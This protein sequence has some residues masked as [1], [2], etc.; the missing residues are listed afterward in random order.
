[1]TT[2]IEKTDAELSTVA[3]K[4]V[5]L[6][7]PQMNPCGHHVRIQVRQADVGERDVVTCFTKREDGVELQAR[8]LITP[9]SAGAFEIVFDLAD[10]EAARIFLQEEWDLHED[11]EDDDDEDDQDDDENDD[12]E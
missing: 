3:L 7:A 1:M 11:F 9:T 4:L 10:F 2:I 12:E 8:A 6:G 5:T